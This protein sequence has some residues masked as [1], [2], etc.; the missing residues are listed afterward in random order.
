MPTKTPPTYPPEELASQALTRALEFAARAGNKTA[1]AR[2]MTDL[3]GQPVTRQ[4]V[5]RWVHADPDKRHQPSLGYGI[6]LIWTAEALLTDTMPPRPTTLT[7]TIKK[8][9]TK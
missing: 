6:A 8:P 4:M 2:A 5:E 3:T 1:I 9:T 7:I